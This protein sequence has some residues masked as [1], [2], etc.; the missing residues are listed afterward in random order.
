MQERCLSFAKRGWVVLLVEP[1]GQTERGENPLWSESHD[2]QAMAFLLT[3]G[4]SLMGLIMADHQAELSWLLARPEVDAERVAV[5]GVSM[6]G[7]HSLWFAALEPRARAAVAVAVAP[8][9]RANWGASPHGMCDLMVDLFHVA[10]DEL[11]R[12]LVAPRPLLE[13]CPSVQTPLTSEGERLLREGQ[14]DQDGAKRRYSLVAAQIPALHPMTRQTYALLG[15]DGRYGYEIVD[16]P[17]DYTRSMRERAAGF[18]TQWWADGSRSASLAEPALR[19]IRDKKLAQETLDF[20]PDGRRPADILSPT[21]YVQRELRR[22]IERLAPP[23]KTRQTWQSQ[24]ERLRRQILGLLGTPLDVKEVS[25]K[26]VG[27]FRTEQG[28]CRKLVAQ[29]DA[30]IEIPLHLFAPARGVRADG[31][32]VVFLHPDGTKSTSASDERRRLTAAGAWVACP[33]LRSTGETH[34][35]EQGGYNGFRDFDVGVAALKLGETL[36]GYWVRDCLVAMAVAQ[37]AAGGHLQVTIHG[38]GEMGLVALLVAA[39]EDDV[40]AVEVRGLLT[41]YYSAAGYGLPFAYCDDKGDKSVRG[42]KLFGYG[43]IAPCIPH[44]LKYADIPQIMALVAPRPLR[45]VEPKWASGDPVPPADRAAALR[46]TS[47]VYALYGCRPA[48]D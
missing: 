3:G 33:D 17:H 25:C 38:E 44:I 6:G 20:W 47:D 29:A 1:F 9:A 22:L 18:L 14:I 16:G 8:L 2:S 27:T 46:W 34:F 10:D 30:G 4:Q 23:P 40:A 41:S 21:A 7:T 24:R 32:L 36:A 11:I 19:P 13:I 26:T 37:Q 15:A 12:A 28:E 5:T 42:R 43:S 45:V 48:L 39:H 31:R 35:N